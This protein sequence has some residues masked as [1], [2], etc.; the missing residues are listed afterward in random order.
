MPLSFGRLPDMLHPRGRLGLRCGV[1][2][3]RQLAACGVSPVSSQL[4][5]GLGQQGR[6]TYVYN[7]MYNMA[8]SI[9]L[10]IGR[11]HLG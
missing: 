1:G 4:L 6:D 2:P 7:V 3:L 9:L 5:H 11:S 8:I 10:R